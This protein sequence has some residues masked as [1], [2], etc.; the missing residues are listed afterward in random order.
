MT[1][2]AVMARCALLTAAFAVVAG[3]ASAPFE[4]HLAARQWPEAAI[5]FAADASL[6]SDPDALYAAGVLFGT[7][8]R[9]TYDPE[10][11]TDLLQLLLTRYPMTRHRAA[12]QER[13]A[14]LTEIRALRLEL[15]RLKEIDLAPPPKRPTA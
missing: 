1:R 8:D 9:A 3:C 15:E 4:R 6:L 12:A 10:R 13:L 5:A 2:L 11:A 14:L 7:P